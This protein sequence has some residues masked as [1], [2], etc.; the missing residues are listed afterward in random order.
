MQAIFKEGR[1]AI[2]L[3]K[4]ILDNMRNFKILLL[5]R[6]CVSMPFRLPYRP[7]FSAFC[8]AFSFR[9]LFLVPVRFPCR[10]ES[11]KACSAPGGFVWVVRLKTGMKR[12]VRSVNLHFFVGCRD[13]FVACPENFAFM[14]WKISFSAAGNID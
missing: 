10:V 3:K 11:G 14:P 12:P 4:Q 7:F 13:F 5:F 9:W 1:E 8:S 6:I 2:V